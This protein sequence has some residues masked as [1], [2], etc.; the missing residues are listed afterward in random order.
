LIVAIAMLAG[1]LGSGVSNITMAVVL[2]P[3]REDLGWSRILTA[4]AITRD[5]LPVESCYRSLDRWLSLGTSLA[6]SAG[7][8]I[9]TYWRLL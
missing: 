2:K 9:V 3:I 1:C 7:V 4:A 8:G 6:A 5:R